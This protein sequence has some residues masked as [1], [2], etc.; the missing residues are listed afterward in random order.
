MAS[1][2]LLKGGKRKIDYHFPIIKTKKELNN[3]IEQ[4]KINNENKNIKEYKSNNTKLHS[5]IYKNQIN[6]YNTV[7]NSLNYFF[8]FL[9]ICIFVS[10]RNGKI[11]DYKHLTN[12]NFENDWDLLI[13]VKKYKNKKTNIYKRFEKFEYNTKKWTA[14]NCLLGST[15]PRTYSERRMFHFYDMLEEACKNE[16]YTCD[17]IMNRRDFPMLQKNGEHPYFHIVNPK[18]YKF[19]SPILPVLSVCSSD[20]FAD[21]PIPNE[22]DWELAS[23]KIFAPDLRSQYIHK[24]NK[25]DIKWENKKN[26][27]VFRGKATGCGTTIE[28][29]QRLKLYYLSKKWESENPNLLDAGVTGWNIREKMLE[30]GKLSFINPILLPSNIKKLSPR[31]NHEE[32]LQFKY[33]INVDGHVSANR[34]SHLL[35]IDC[36]VLHVASNYGWKVWFFDLLI[37]YKHYIPIKNDLSD[38]KNQIE[39]CKNNDDKCKA[40]SKNASKFYKKYLTKKGIIKYFKKLLSEI[41]SFQEKK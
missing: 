14:N 36:V 3:F 29:N 10:I 35:Y 20:N 21:I 5:N 34:L 2:K 17:F 31:L 24:K 25:S 23:Q 8:D 32:Q 19:K 11:K 30:K 40:I 15:L 39:W 27:A 7:I 28:T 16:T 26:I 4:Y 12:I 38:L 1:K 41:E 37:P 18:N 13:N 9:T 6:L 33:H 22:D